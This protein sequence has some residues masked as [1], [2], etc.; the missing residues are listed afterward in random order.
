[1]LPLSKI[2]TRDKFG[3]WL[4]ANNIRG[5]GV[6]IGTY[7]GDY[8]RVLSG[9]WSGQLYTVDP[10][11]W[12]E[13]PTY[14]DGCRIDW[15]SPDKSELDPEKVRLAAKD[16][17]HT[18]KNC[19]MMHMTSLEA[20]KEFPD[21]SLSFVYIDGDHS[22]ESVEADIAAWYPK[23]RSGG[24]FCGHDFYDRDD[25]M[26]KGGVFSVLWEWSHRYCLKPHVTQCTS[27]WF[28]KP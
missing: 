25:E 5:N 23:V 9:Q 2:A 12:Q 10:Y 3:A 26:M 20:A 11:N 28:I 7:Y 15:R 6:E 19:Q 13:T 24:I 4:E 22:R 1:M 16:N 17:L 21:E 14:V 27:W 8:A 18:S